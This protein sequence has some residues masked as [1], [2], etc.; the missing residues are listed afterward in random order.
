M[1]Y[2][3]LRNKSEVLRKV[4]AILRSARRE[5]EAF[6]AVAG[7]ISDRQGTLNQQSIETAYDSIGQLDWQVVEAAVKEIRA[8]AGER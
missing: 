5:L 2:E 8:A 1:S 4:V 6:E 3:E 7:K